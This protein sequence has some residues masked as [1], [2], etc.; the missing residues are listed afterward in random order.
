MRKLIAN[1][2]ILYLSH[3]YK[4][5]DELPPNNQEMVEAW[6]EAN[7]AHWEGDSA[8]ESPEDNNQIEDNIQ[9]KEVT[10]V[11]AKLVTAEPGMA[12]IDSTT[13]EDVLIGKVE[14]GK[15]KK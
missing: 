8:E 10:D 7:T 1:N 6:I 2:Y 15:G 13:G 4:P 9:D 11:E 12:G 5:G 3:Q 14:K